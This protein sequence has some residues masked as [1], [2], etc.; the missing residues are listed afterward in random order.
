MAFFLTHLKR[1]LCN[2]PGLTAENAE[3]LQEIDSAHSAFS[4]VK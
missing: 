3:I 4:A 2:R 1:V